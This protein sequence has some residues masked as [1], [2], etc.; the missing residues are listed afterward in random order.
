MS[1]KSI[2]IL[3]T[4]LGLLAGAV[5][6]GLLVSLE[7]KKEEAVS[8]ERALWQQK[9]AELEREKGKLEQE[10]KKLGQELQVAEQGEQLEP[11]R[12]QE[13]FGARGA[14][15]PVGELAHPEVVASVEAF[16]AY[17]DRKGYLRERGITMSA[18]DFCRFV[19]ERLQAQTPVVSG[20]GLD[21]YVL[22]KNISFF[23]RTLG[24]NEVLAIRD[25]V[26]GEADVIEEAAALFYRWLDPEQ[27]VDD[28]ARITIPFSTM[29]EYAAFFLQTIAGRA[30]L[31]R[32]DAR[33]RL[34]AQYYSVC[35]VDRAEDKMLNTYG[36]DLMEHVT[37]LLQEIKSSRLLRKRQAYVEQL[38][39][40]RK[41]RMRIRIGP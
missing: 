40:I 33:V 13:V 22:L 39:T 23:F 41:K 4:V 19:I 17:L 30:Y 11:G 15:A 8:R 3:V 24:K 35:I 28:S 32:R 5:Y 27:V 1:K 37:S 7:K 18:R 38:E 29:Y 34:L 26:H 14:E 6:V 12:Q 9:A 36:V 16:F 10:V 31:F 20:E 2:L 25:I 21:A